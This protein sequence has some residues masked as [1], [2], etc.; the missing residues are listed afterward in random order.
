M[1]KRRA[2]KAGS[3]A[4]RAPKARRLAKR[5]AAVRK[6]A[7]VSAEARAAVL[8]ALRRAGGR[9]LS[10]SKLGCKR[11]GDSRHRALRALVGSGEA[12]VFGD[13]REA[14]AVVADRAPTAEAVAKKV[15]ARA[16]MRRGAALV[17]DEMVAWCSATEA[18]LLDAALRA[19]V[20]SG[21]LVPLRSGEGTLYTH[22]GSVAGVP[23][24]TRPVAPEPEKSADQE[25]RLR[26]I[27][28][29]RRLVER[30]G[31]GDVV[32][33]ELRR[34]AGLPQGDLAAWLLEQSRCGRA[35]LG[36]G[37]WSLADEAARGAAVVAAGEPHLRVRLVI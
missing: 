23:A 5:T 24:A 33:A 16:S 13:G 1:R 9:G 29:Y 32:I 37:D 18:F 19:L 2:A 35:H 36:R 21:R 10:L 3:K 15:E 27:E 31:F 34:E 25:N 22:V 11:S 4:K 8:V 26:I 12:I 20:K 14:V 17:R 7:L 30:E 28:A 6:P